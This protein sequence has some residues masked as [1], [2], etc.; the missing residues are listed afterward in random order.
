MREVTDRTANLFDDLEDE[1]PMDQVAE[2]PVPEE[3]VQPVP[4]ADSAPV[5]E[6]STAFD[7]SSADSVREAAE[8]AEAL[9][10]YLEKVKLDTANAERQRI[11]NEMRREQGSVERAQAYH[12]WLIDQIENGADPEELKK[13]TPL[14][15]TANAGWAQAQVLRELAGQAIEMASPEVKATLQQS[16][17]DADSPE[18]VQRIASRVIQAVVDKNSADV[19]SNLDFNNLQEH[20]RFSEWL[21]SQVKARMEEEM[22]AQETQSKSRPQAPAVPS[23]TASTGGISAEQFVSMDKAAQDK[24]LSNLTEEQED[25]LM[26]ALYE[27]ARGG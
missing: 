23:G 20:P 7:L 6:T 12:Q 25:A 15:V 3:E 5:P 14:Y 9:K 19:L 17:D 13:Q 8:K 1:L 24:Y 27:A 4:D 10:N 21:T 2:A 18:A 11:Q 22:K 16:L 26:T